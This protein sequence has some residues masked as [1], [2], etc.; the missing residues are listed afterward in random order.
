MARYSY[1]F[2]SL[3]ALAIFGLLILVPRSQIAPKENNQIRK[4][5]SH[6]NI[7]NEKN[8]KERAPHTVSSRPAHSDGYY[9]CRERLDK[10]S[11]AKG[12]SEWSLDTWQR[13]Y[14]QRLE[15][16]TWQPANLA[17][18]HN[19]LFVDGREECER[20]RE[21]II[22]V[23]Q[24]TFRGH[25]VLLVYYPE[26]RDRCGRLAKD[27]SVE[28][29]FH[30]SPRWEWTLFMYHGV[31]SYFESNPK[32]LSKY[33][34]AAMVRP[35]H[36]VWCS[37][38]FDDIAAFNESVYAIYFKDPRSNAVLE[39]YHNSK[40]GAEVIN[41]HFLFST[42][43]GLNAIVRVVLGAVS[44]Q[45]QG[46]MRRGADPSW[47][48]LRSDPDAQRYATE[49]VRKYRFVEKDTCVLGETICSATTKGVTLGNF[50][51]YKADNSGN[52]LYS[53]YCYLEHRY[54][55]W[56]VPPSVSLASVATPKIMSA[57]KTLKEARGKGGVNDVFS[58]PSASDTDRDASPEC[59]NG[60]LAVLTMMGGYTM[61]R[62]KEYIGSFLFYADPKCTKLVLLL[63]ERTGIH[64]VA[65]M[66]P[67][68]VEVV[69]YTEEFIPKTWIKRGIIDQRHEVVLNWLEKNYKGFRYIMANDSKDIV[70][71]SDPLKQLIATLSE[72]GFLNTE[73]AG[74]VVESFGS[75]SFS[76][77]DEGINMAQ[78]KWMRTCEMSKKKKKVLI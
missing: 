70:Y 62:V 69:F 57:V 5:I 12:T 32:A 2:I 31:A 11:A 23:R 26:D 4:K 38:P 34:A 61:D 58:N 17:S 36:I 73:F 60:K 7:E 44:R 56:E 16:E 6:V 28:I 51:C 41:D 49:V 59:P 71:L 19:L 76:W 33:S 13:E 52:P 77:S 55:V 29:H 21:F 20:Y 8:G 48:Y 46:T 47:S 63:K 25:I 54:P 9:D 66:Y 18:D 75:G 67:R 14:C 30:D 42:P 10:S 45:L 37:N 39:S 24:S 35:D 53:P 40:P 68:R 1:R 3:C 22:K 65:E 78:K 64:K 74:S 27:L 15:R 43:T 72:G 50:Y